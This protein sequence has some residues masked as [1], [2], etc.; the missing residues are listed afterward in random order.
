MAFVVALAVALVATPIAVWS[1]TRLGVVDRPGPLKPQATAVPYLGGAAVYAALIGPV[2]VDRPLLLLPLGLALAA[3]LLD[4]V[5]P[6]SVGFRLACQ[7]VVAATAALTT[8][9]PSAGARAVTALLVLGLANAVN[10][11]DGLDGLAAGCG[12]V[13]AIGLALLGG[14]A[15]TPAL[16]L[17]G[18]LAGF[19]AYNRP[20]ARVYLGDAGAYV[21]GTG[22]AVLSMLMID[23]RDDGVAWIA[24]PFLVA[25]PVVDTALAIVRRLRSRQA[26]S[27]GDRSHVY[28][29]LEN[30]FRRSSVAAMLVCVVAQLLLT[31]VGVAIAELDVAPAIG[32]AAACVAAVAAVLTLGGFVATPAPGP[33]T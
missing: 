2:A 23:S 14:S 11:L 17:A 33:S 29:Q 3:G 10:L 31:A 16:A 4:D 5:R 9:A 32:V 28:D 24:V 26:L 7:L 22:L 6:R 18:A 30:R 27:A 20:P 13:S 25:V 1:A 8:P 21:I 19:L 12:F 15:R